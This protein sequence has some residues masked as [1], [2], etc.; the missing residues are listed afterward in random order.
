MH[1]QIFRIC[2]IKTVAKMILY[3]KSMCNAGI[4]VPKKI[5]YEN[6]CGSHK[7]KNNGKEQQIVQKEFTGLWHNKHIIL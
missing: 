3:K 2:V 6:V 5:L 4:R 7:F 1:E